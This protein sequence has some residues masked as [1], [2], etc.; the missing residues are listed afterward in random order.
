MSDISITET[1]TEDPAHP[2]ADPGS[3]PR[4]IV[5]TLF[6]PVAL[7]QRFHVRAPWAGVLVLCTLAMAALTMAIPRDL[8]V[9]Q[10]QE[11]MRQNPEMA[12]GGAGPDIDTMV[13]FGRVG[14]VLSQLVLTPLMALAV[15]GLCTLIF[16]R[17]MGGGGTFRKHLAVVSHASVVSVLGFAITLFFMV[18]GGSLTTQLSPALL[19]P[20]L[21]AD[22]FAFR[23]LNALGVFMLWWLGLV[24]A[25]VYAV[26]RRI[27]P[28][29]AAGIT[30][31]L[32]LL[33]VVAVAAI[34]G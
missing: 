32:Y 27:S 16:G 21:D 6:A 18:Q 31:G 5:D 9:A 14:G 34:R 11:A 24:A 8:M 19:L 28:A 15:A 20:E 30:F 22:S 25:G 1:R 13:M 3:L 2:L 29:A 10:I 23:V 33:I 7:F 4:R 17:W 26:N 12:A